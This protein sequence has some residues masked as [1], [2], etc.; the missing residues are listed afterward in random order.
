[1]P[2][3]TNRLTGGE[4]GEKEII[5]ELNWN[6][7]HEQ[8]DAQLRWQQ[9][10][11]DFYA[12]ICF[13]KKSCAACELAIH[14][15]HIRDVAESLES[16]AEKHKEHETEIMLSYQFYYTV[17]R[18]LDAKI[19]K[20]NRDGDAIAHSLLLIEANDVMAKMLSMKNISMIIKAP[21]GLG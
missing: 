21:T 7:H 17:V 12:E 3:T 20:A 18:Q 16:Y 6:D 2:L 4:T 15:G 1:L 5:M 11:N 10:R 19:K 13:Q 9:M 14:N 8:L